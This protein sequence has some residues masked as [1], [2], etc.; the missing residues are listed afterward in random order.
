[1]QANET[2]LSRRAFFSSI[3]RPGKHRSGAELHAVD[4]TTSETSN[5][6]RENQNF[7][8]PSPTRESLRELLRQQVGHSSLSEPHGK[9]PWQTM[10]V[11]E[12]NCIACGICVAVCPTRALRKENANGQLIRY[13]NSALCTNCHLCSEACPQKVISFEEGDNIASIIDDTSAIVARIDLTSC[14]VCGETIPRKEG[15]VC[16][17]CRKRQLSPMFM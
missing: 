7:T 16:M 6:T 4:K 14:A 12:K 2:R 17:T 10:K 3:A 8:R 5:G 11:D 13:F 9:F 15:K 1:M